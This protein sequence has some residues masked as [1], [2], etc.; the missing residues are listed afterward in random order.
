MWG[1]NDG[2][3]CNIL[4][5][6]CSCWLRSLLTSNPWVAQASMDFCSFSPRD[7]SKSSGGK[8]PCFTGP[9]NSSKFSHHHPPPLS[10][11]R[12]PFQIS[13]AENFRWLHS[14]GAQ[15]NHK[16][17]GLRWK[18]FNNNTKNLWSLVMSRSWTTRNIWGIVRI[19]QRITN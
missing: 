2:D 10:F 16:K 19:S 3:L 15:S 1:Q 12:N 4:D 6:A 11:P 8:G 7:T 18:T 5:I 13:E 9:S 14:T 17:I